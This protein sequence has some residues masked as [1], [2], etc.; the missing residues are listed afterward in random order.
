MSI[1]EVI[2]ISDMAPPTDPADF[3]KLRSIE[4][5]N[6]DPDA[7]PPTFSERMKRNFDMFV[8]VSK[9][10]PLSQTVCLKEALIFGK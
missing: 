1:D 6:I 8:E 3:S 4:P 9:N 2:F 5:I 10:R 7:P